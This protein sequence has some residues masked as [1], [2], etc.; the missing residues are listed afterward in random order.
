MDFDFKKYEENE[1]TVTYWIESF[2]DEKPE[3]VV[4]SIPVKG[5]CSFNKF[6][7]QMVF[8]PEKSD[9]FFF[10]EAPW[11]HIFNQLEQLYRRGLPFPDRYIC[12]RE[13]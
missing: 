3:D 1:A 11:L 12:T 2:I 6:S 13:D 4:F 9:S 7:K 10:Q 5:L 8:D